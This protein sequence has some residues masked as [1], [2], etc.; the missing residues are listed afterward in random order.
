MRLRDKMGEWSIL[1]AGLC[2]IAVILFMTSTES[3]V[4]PSGA[5]SQG[6][7]PTASR[8]A[9]QAPTAGA[10]PA[11]AGSTGQA[12]CDPTIIASDNV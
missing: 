3:L 8:I 12:L 9:Q 4:P 6:S 5:P 11:A 1:G 7:Q 2:I 10:I